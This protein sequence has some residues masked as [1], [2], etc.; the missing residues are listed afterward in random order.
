MGKWMERAA[1]MK[2][3][4]VC[5]NSVIG[6]ESPDPE[7]PDGPYGTIGAIDTEV[8]SLPPPARPVAKSE[9]ISVLPPEPPNEWGLSHDTY[10]R[11]R[12]LKT[13][14]TGRSLTR[15]ELWGGF[16]CDAVLF[17]KNGWAAKAVALG[18]SEMEIF[19]LAQTGKWLGVTSR[20]FG[21]Q[22]LGLTADLVTVRE[23][24]GTSRLL[25]LP[26]RD[27]AVMIWEIGL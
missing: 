7:G 11:L 2:G 19:G 24:H 25:R 9:T 15:P 1:R 21:C 3:G 16:V 14:P 20:L 18:W 26:P 23:L 17:A 4:N 5:A 13:S 27:D 8:A 6:A 10:W 22:V 12:R